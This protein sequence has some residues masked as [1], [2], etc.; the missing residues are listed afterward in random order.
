MASLRGRM[1]EDMELAGLSPRTR[2]AYTQA[3]K[4]RG[5]PPARLPQRVALPEVPL[6][7]KPPMHR[8]PGAKSAAEVKRALDR[9]RPSAARRGYG[10]RWRRGRAAF[11]AQH[12]LCAACQAL[13]RVVP[14]TV[15]DHVVPHRGDQRL[16]WD[17]SNWAP[18][19][20]PCHDAKTAREGRWG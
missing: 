14:A 5:T 10:P 16:F 6:P 2:Q 4:P 17:Q 15:V 18:A 19:C 13:G 20:K 1:I 8:P 12:P 7:S 3:V 9:Q 11:L